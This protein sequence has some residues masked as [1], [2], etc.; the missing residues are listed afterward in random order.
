MR[1]RRR[2]SQ[3]PII[4]RKSYATES[5]TDLIL[6]SISVVSER[7]RATTTHADAVDALFIA[8]PKRGALVSEVGAARTSSPYRSSRP[9]G[10]PKT[11]RGAFVKHTEAALAH[12]PL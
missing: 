7:G 3:K 4:I 2:A 9:R 1:T 8:W 5:C 11:R 12:F 6:F 10:S